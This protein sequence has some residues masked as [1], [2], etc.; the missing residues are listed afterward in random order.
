MEFI[1]K[2]TINKNRE[3]VIRLWSDKDS[4]KHWQD[5][6]ESIETFEGVPG[7]KGSKA[8][9]IYQYGKRKMEL[10]E[11]VVENNLPE[12]FNATYEHV[13]MINTSISEFN[14]IDEN[15]TEW[16]YKI[17]YIKFNA[18]LPKVMMYL[19]PGMAKKQTQKWLDQFKI[20]AEGSLN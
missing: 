17:D 16:I 1:C 19:F 12:E 7:E 3:D 20:F 2:V 11:T 13:H 9:I 14:M 5:G 6:F 18:F 4:F 8:R 10:I 15:T